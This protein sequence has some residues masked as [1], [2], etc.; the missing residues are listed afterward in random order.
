MESMNIQIFSESGGSVLS[1]SGYCSSC[2]RD[3]IF[4]GADARPLGLELMEQLVR[5]K[6]IDQDSPDNSDQQ[7]LS[8]DSLFG[9]ARGKMFGVMECLT[10]DGITM[11]FKAFSGQ[12]NG[13]W[14]VDGWVPPLFDADKWSLV[15]TGTERAI[16][17]LGEEIETCPDDPW[18]RKRLLQERKLLSQKLM[19]DLHAL[20][21]LTNFR[22]LTL[23]LTDLFPEQSG[24][25]TGTG[26]C[27]APKLLNFAAAHDLIPIGI[28][29]F[30]WGREN[31]SGNRQ[32]RQFYLPCK[33]KCGPILGFLLCGLEEL[34]ERQR[35]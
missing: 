16:K 7:T 25:P 9:Q 33:E 26:D 1:Y 27:C 17:K 18:R 30:Y 19:K 31:K 15:N 35:L 3:H 13:L 34:Y 6:C 20:Y 10:D 23:S 4:F 21:R 2:G 32:H 29:E 8:T 28:C 12:F 24:I 14:Q 11:Y 22:G 5:R